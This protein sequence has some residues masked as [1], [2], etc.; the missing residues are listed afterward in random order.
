MTTE[1][2]AQGVDGLAEVMGLLRKATPGKW[3]SKVD[4]NDYGGWKPMTQEVSI[5]SGETLIA[6]YSLDYD[7]YPHDNAENAENAANAEAMAAAVNYLRSH[8]EAIRELV[9][10][11]RALQTAIRDDLIQNTSDEDSVG[12]LSD[13]ADAAL[14]KFPEPRP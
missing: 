9:E 7:D 1:R 13:F 6:H 8:G 2:N 4:E 12:V 11:V 14:A 10:I 3:D 5:Y